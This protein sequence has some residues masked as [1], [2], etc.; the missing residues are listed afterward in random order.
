[1]RLY[2]PWLE[3][4]TKAWYDGSACHTYFPPGRDPQ[5]TQAL[6]GVDQGCP[7]GALLFAIGIRAPIEYVLEY[8]RSVDENSDLLFY[9]DDGYF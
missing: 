2:A 4:V 9:L 1:M 8:A 7:L 3:G 6:R 5:R